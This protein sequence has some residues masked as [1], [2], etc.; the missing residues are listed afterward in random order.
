MTKTFI[1]L[2]TIL[3]IRLTTAFFKRRHMMGSLLTLSAATKAFEEGY[4]TVSRHEERFSLY[5]RMYSKD[6]SSS[7]PL[8]VLHGGPYV[9]LPSTCSTK[10][11][12]RLTIILI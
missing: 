7:I 2:M 10:E 3:T 9:K 1:V 6:E 4:V 5:Y 12:G 11:V 8:V